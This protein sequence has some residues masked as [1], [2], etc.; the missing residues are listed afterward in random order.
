MAVIEIGRREYEMVSPRS[1]PLTV[2]TD[3]LVRVSA[4]LENKLSR[5]GGGGGGGGDDDGSSPRFEL[6]S[7]PV[8]VPPFGHTI[9]KRMR[10]I[11]RIPRWIEAGE[12]KL[13]PVNGMKISLPR[14]YQP[15][16]QGNR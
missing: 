10:V 9:L 8:T 13:R 7:L 2:T 3:S 1:I 5:H 6:V 12:R 16:S 15:F 14:G 11:D 4:K